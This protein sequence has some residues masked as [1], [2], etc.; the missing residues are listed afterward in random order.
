MHINIIVAAAVSSLCSLLSSMA[1]TND[2]AGLP[3]NESL[4]KMVYHIGYSCYIKQQYEQADIMLR[5][6]LL[7]LLNEPKTEW[8]YQAERL[9]MSNLM[10][11]FYP[12]NTYWQKYQWMIACMSDDRLFDIESVFRKYGNYI[13]KDDKETLISDNMDVIEMNIKTPDVLSIRIILLNRR[14]TMI[15]TMAGNTIRIFRHQMLE[16]GDRDFP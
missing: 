8:H 6:V 15:V 10:Y 16:S 11:A 2:S 4:V 3:D 13:G 5:Y 14:V 7:C 1:S 12:N 9:L